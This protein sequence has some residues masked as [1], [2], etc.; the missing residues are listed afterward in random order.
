[1][2]AQTGNQE[3]NSAGLQTMNTGD[4]IVAEMGPTFAIGI[5][6]EFAATLPLSGAE[7]FLA[8]DKQRSE[9]GSYVLGQMISERPEL[10]HMGSLKA[11][12]L[13][14]ELIERSGLDDASASLILLLSSELDELPE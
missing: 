2:E 4:S 11:N 14:R 9:V 1:M 6:D 13:R 3:E 8:T 5:R 10:R 7:A 12:T